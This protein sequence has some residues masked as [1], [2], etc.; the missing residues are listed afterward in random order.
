MAV[1]ATAAEQRK[2]L[3]IAGI[4]TKLIQLKHQQASLPELARAQDLEVEL[5]SIELKIVAVETEL[6]DLIAVQAKAEEDVAQVTAR[7][8]RDEAR[9]AD[10]ATTAKELEGLQHELKTLASRLTEL[11]DSELEVMQQVE[12]ANSVL[13]ELTS[14]QSRVS[15]ELNLAQQELTAKIAQLDDETVGLRISREEQLKALPVELVELYEK[16]KSDRGEVGAVMLHRGACQGCHL[17]VDAAELVRIKALPED[18]IVRC[19]ECRR[20]LVRTVESGL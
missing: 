16:I 15:T 10:S 6:A 12:D 11:E 18:T 7:I 19:D 9:L 5:G 8:A 4:D 17:A 2:L 1:T 3:D 13:T 14:D 20:I